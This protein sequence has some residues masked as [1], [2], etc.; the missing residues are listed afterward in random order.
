[1]T[2]NSLTE[3]LKAAYKLSNCEKCL[4]P[5][6]SHNRLGRPGE[7]SGPERVQQDLALKEDKV[8]KRGAV[9]RAQVHQ[10][11]AVVGPTDGEGKKQGRQ[12]SSGRAVK[13]HDRKMGDRS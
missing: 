5:T 13:F 6:H 1:M 4:E 7:H 3:A 2:N 12:V 8:Q 11:R 9:L 10:E